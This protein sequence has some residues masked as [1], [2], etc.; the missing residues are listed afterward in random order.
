M[1]KDRDDGE[2]F[3]ADGVSIE[4]VE[5]LRDVAPE[6]YVVFDIP[7]EG[8]APNN[9]HWT[10][11]T[12]MTIWHDGDWLIYA[13][14]LAH[15]RPSAGRRYWIVDC[16]FY[17]GPDGTGSLLHERSYVLRSLT[18]RQQRWEVSSQ[19]HDQR[20]EDVMGDVRSVNYNQSIRSR[21]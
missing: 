15:Q 18:H 13:K 11:P 3:T 7:L 5:F 10:A 17:S 6:R 1:A 8:W 21:V 14:H 20:L 19:D 12:H 9:F 16:R 4:K 2:E